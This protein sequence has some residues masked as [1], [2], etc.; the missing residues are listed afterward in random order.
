MKHGSLIR[1]AGAKEV[2]ETLSEIK[3]KG[4]KKRTVVATRDQV[5][6]IA[7]EAEKAGY[8]SFAV[9]ILLQFEFALRAVDIRGQ[10]L[11]APNTDGGIRRNGKRWQDGLT[12]DMFDEDF[13]AFEKVIS[14]TEKTLD[15]AY[16][17]SLEFLPELRQ[18]I[19]ALAPP[20]ARVGPVIL[21]SRRG[22]GLPYTRYG[23]SQAWARF[24]KA[25]GV[26]EDVQA[27]DMRA[28]AISE[29]DMLGVSREMLSQAAQHSNLDTTA[30]YVRNRSKAV[31]NVVE[32][33]QS[34]N[35][36]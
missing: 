4:P 30:R 6:A 26:P 8:H 10:W 34:K 11:D 31:A 23:W 36:S 1:A 27:R 28:G 9:G 5:Y 19:L 2:K 16:H 17:F 32:L 3:F 24:R 20:E 21:S 22:K 12:W 13:T 15:E 25:A 29:A 7:A 35:R 18:K 33:R 14:K